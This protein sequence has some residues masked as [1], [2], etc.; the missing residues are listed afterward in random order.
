MSFKDKGEAEM[1]G[2]LFVIITLLLLAGCAILGGMEEREKIYGRAIP[3]ITE[4]FASKQ[5]SAGEDLRVYINASDPDGDM[6]DF[7]YH[8]EQ[9]GVE[10][11]KYP[12]G[13]TKIKKDN[14]K[15]LSGYLYL[16]TSDVDSPINPTL[17]LWVRDKAG[18]VSAPVKFRLQVV[19]PSQKQGLIPQET[20]PPGIFQDKNLGPI[21]SRLTS[22]VG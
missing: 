22:D 4:S 5:V 3:V 15:D 14:Q 2:K 13:F 21:M 1:K 7:L 12:I 11:Y 19:V 18:H 16:S 9:A 20:P 10:L 8:I 17:I 6:S